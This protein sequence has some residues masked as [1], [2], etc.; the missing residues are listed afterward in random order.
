VIIKLE[1]SEDMGESEELL[2]LLESYQAVRRG[3]FRLSSGKH[4]DT[5]VQCALVLQH[6]REAERLADLL[7]KRF[8]GV[9]VD[10]V[11][12]PALGGVIIGFM[13]ARALRCRF[14]FAE[15]KEG[16]MEI[17]RGQEL[18]AGERILLVEDVVTTGGSLDE[19]AALAEGMGARVVGRAALV[20]RG[21]RVGREIT[22]LLE[23]PLSTWE[24]QDCPLCRRGESLEA[25]GS[26]HS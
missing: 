11:F 4:S 1:G 26:R 2:G 6:P 16:R 3:H 19:I 14:V 10:T 12:S 18:H 15:R 13:V 20:L 22:A 25:P 21:E 17:R 24:P 9:E 23:L 5:Y 7:A 8:E